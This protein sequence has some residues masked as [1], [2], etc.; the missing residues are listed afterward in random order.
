[1][2]PGLGGRWECFRCSSKFYDLGK[3]DPI[4]PKCGADQREKPREKPTPSTPPPEKPRRANVPMGSLLDEDEE[5][6]EEFEAEET[7]LAGLDA[8]AFLTESTPEDEDEDVDVNT[9]EEE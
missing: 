6:I 7:D 4:C 2:K 5:P 9:I 3:P 1:M 8:E